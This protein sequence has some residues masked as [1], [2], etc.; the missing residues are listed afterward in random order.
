MKYSYI[1]EVTIDRSDL[2]TFL[3]IYPIREGVSAKGFR[4]IVSG[5]YAGVSRQT[6]AYDKSAVVLIGIACLI[7]EAPVVVESVVQM[8]D[9]SISAYR[10][11]HIYRAFTDDFHDKVVS[12]VRIGIIRADLIRCYDKAVLAEDAR[13][14][15]DRDIAVHHVQQFVDVEIYAEIGIDEDGDTAARVSQRAGALLTAQAANC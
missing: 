10:V 15:A 5:L 6:V 8:L 13:V 9:I 2:C 3:I 1:P 7:A 4:C 12:A 11:C 14:A